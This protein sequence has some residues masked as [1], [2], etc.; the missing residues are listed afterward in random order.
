MIYT[1]LTN[2]MDF[3]IAPLILILMIIATHIDWNYWK[4]K[5]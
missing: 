2:Q 1:P 4:K 5:K 3:F